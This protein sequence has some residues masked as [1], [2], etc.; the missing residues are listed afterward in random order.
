MT[1]KL[2]KIDD[3]HAVSG[4]VR[5]LITKCW[6]VYAFDDEERTYCCSSLP[7]REL[8]PVTTVFDPK[9]DLTEA[10]REALF[11]AELEGGLDWSSVEYMSLYSV[12]GCPQHVAEI[13][14]SEDIEFLVA[15]LRDRWEQGEINF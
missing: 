5:K 11:D 14:D 9:P 2:V 15:D 10:E 1:W 12:D 7:M 8:Y 4:D 13:D 6:D 3:T